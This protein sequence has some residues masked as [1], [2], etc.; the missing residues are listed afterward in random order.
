MAFRSIQF[1]PG[2]NSQLTPTL[3][4]TGWFGEVPE[5]YGELPA[6]NL[7]R[8]SASNQ[9]QPEVIG[10][11]GYFLQPATQ[12]VGVCRG[13]HSWATVAGFPTLGAGTNSRL[14]VT[15]SGVAYDVTPIYATSNHASSH[16]TDNCI[17]TISGSPTVTI[18]DANYTPAAG[19]WVT[20]SG[21]TAV[22]GLTISGLY[23]IQTVGSG[24]YTITAAS[25]AS[26]TATGGGTA[27]VLQYYLPTGPVDSN[28]AL[29]WGINGWGQGAW[30]TPRPQ[31]KVI[32]PAIWHIDNWNEEMIAC[33]A[34]YTI[35]D[36]QPSSGT[37]THATAITNA[38]PNA[39]GALVSPALLQIIAWGTNIPNAVAGTWSTAQNPMTIAWSD[40]GNYNSWFAS[41][42]NAAGS[43]TLTQGSQIM[44]CVRSQGQ[45]LVWT[46]TSL[47][48]MQFINVPLVYSF[49]E[50]GS[51]CGSISTKAA[52]VIG[53]QAFWWGS[54]E[55]YTYNGAVQPIP[56]FIRDL[57]FNN[58]NTGQQLKITA[59]VN[60]E[61]SE[62]IWDFPSLN[63]SENDSYISYN[64]INHTWGY[65]VNVN[66]YM[67][68]GRTCRI[69]Q[70][71][72]GFPIA[73]DAS[74]NI[75]YQEYGYSAGGQPMPWALQ[76]GFVDVAEGEELSFVDWIIPDQYLSGT[77]PAVGITLYAQEYPSDEITGQQ[78]ISG[79]YAVTPT[80]QYVP[81]RV[82][83][84][85]I[86][87]QF[88]NSTN[89]APLFWRL[90]RVRIRAAIDGRR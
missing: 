86:A 68:V 1:Q 21:A 30:D 64:Y 67:L 18:T 66:G 83:A 33:R 89:A 50:L 37:G 28:Q 58:L 63:S 17:A 39:N 31:G 77:N 78:V 11:W 25:N 57:A 29:G 42:S 56:C 62:I 12:L 44:Q 47:L 53:Q 69:D 70:G 76:S 15:Q 51:G 84:R 88:S 3:N 26:G 71:V 54:Q 2:L 43:I 48:S 82:R 72:F 90:G 46:D 61:F 8:W 75:W 24:T 34:G 9:G 40:F 23:L 65:G 73:T 52:V 5:T 14:Y 4:R 49:Q 35:Y 80:T 10:G 20:I 45:V 41:A 32:P 7:I 59:S 74:S 38:P 81:V 6:S 79:P 22:G 36:W 19:D 87:I 27:I 60:S 13:L 55:F 16:P 85:Q